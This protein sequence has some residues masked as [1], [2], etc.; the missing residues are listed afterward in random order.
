SWGNVM[1][2]DEEPKTDPSAGEAP[3]EEATDPA[4]KPPEP[5]PEPAPAPPPEDPGAKRRA[6]VQRLKHEAEEA[7]RK[8]A[9]LREEGAAT[10]VSIEHSDRVKALEDKL[11]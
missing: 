9:Q 2:G 8:V 11:F 5:E 10:P 3:K 4:A 6:E 7:R 1:P